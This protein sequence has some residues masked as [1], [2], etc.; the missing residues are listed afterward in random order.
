[1]LCVRCGVSNYSVV[2]FFPDR[3]RWFADS[4]PML[5]EDLYRNMPKLNRGATP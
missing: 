2:R 5:T 3:F 1:M 4:Y